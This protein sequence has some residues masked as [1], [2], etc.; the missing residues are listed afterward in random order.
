MTSKYKVELLLWAAVLF[1][2]GNYTVGKFGMRDFSPLL[3]TALR[4]IIATP[5]LFLLLKHREGGLG[6]SRPDLPRIIAVG[7]V[8]IAIYQTVYIAAV[9]YASV[10]NAALGLGVSPI[11]TILLGAAA[12]QEKPN[13]PA[14]AG[15]IAAFA[16]LFLVIRFSPA[17]SGL[18]T[19]GLLGDG[20]ALAAGFLWGLYPILATPLLK[21]HSSLWVT[22]HASLVGTIILL[23][24]AL[25][26]VG[27]FAWQAVSPAGW[28]SLFYSIGPAT[29]IALVAWNHGVEKIGANQVMIYM[30]LIT[31]VAIIIGVLTIGETVSLLQGVGGVI[32]ICGVV[33]AKQSMS[34]PTSE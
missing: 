33:L 22:S 17:Y 2:A 15:C 19:T 11:F 12:G 4:F 34:K 23:A 13:T 27:T 18:A 3:F 26:E 30:Y 1:W 5:L 31:P 7:I 14:L 16:G 25:P 29:V 8:G 20:L 28:A 21:N 24:C 6:F 10:T 32:T 9:K